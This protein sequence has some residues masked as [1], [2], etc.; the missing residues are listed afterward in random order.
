MSS[1]RRTSKRSVISSA[2]SIIGTAAVAYGAYKA[3]ELAWNY[4]NEDRGKL[5]M[6]NDDFVPGSEPPRNFQNSQLRW[7]MRRQRILRCQEEAINALGDFLPTLRRCIEELTDTSKETKLLKEL[8]TTEANENRRLKEQE[9]WKTIKI[10]AFAQLI[11]TAYAHNILFLVLTVQ[12]HLLGGKLLEE[13]L[14][15]RDTSSSFGA[16]SLASDRMASYQESHRIVLSRTYEY[17]FGQGLQ[18]LVDSTMQAVDVALEDWDVTHP[19]SINTTTEMLDEG[20]KEV[21]KKLE[22]RGGRSCRRPMSILRFLQPPQHGLDSSVNDDLAN[23]IL[24]ETFDL[25][26]SPVFQDAQRDCHSSILK[27][28]YEESWSK[29]FIDPQSPN[30]S[31]QPKPLATVV[32]KLKRTSRSFFGERSVNKQTPRVN[33]YVLTLERIPSVLE[34]G[35]VS[36]N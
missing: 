10:N 12:V 33:L 25:I 5:R 28:M 24:D 26:E 8:R 35:D 23:S 36:F 6:R 16:D 3:I 2:A 14:G 20:I 4:W 18:L 15:S 17:F 30:S 27:L 31:P 13:Q 22:E 21:C 32:T 7:Q 34:L 1:N 9:L 11:V 29:I 19:S